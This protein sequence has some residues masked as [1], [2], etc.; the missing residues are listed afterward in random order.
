MFGTIEQFKPEIMGKGLS[1]VVALPMLS[2]AARKGSCI[3]S[4]TFATA[5]KRGSVRTTFA[6]G[7]IRQFSPRRREASNIVIRK[8]NC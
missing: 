5:M 3:M 1:Q 4:E 2:G 8:A 6:G 7:F